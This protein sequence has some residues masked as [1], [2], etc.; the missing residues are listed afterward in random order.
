MPDGNLG[1]GKSGN[2]KSRNLGIEDIAP[3]GLRSD[4]MTFERLAHNR[5]ITSGSWAD[6]EDVHTNFLKSI[7]PFMSKHM[8]VAVSTNFECGTCSRI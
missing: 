8:S 3:L 6:I 5:S 2:W 7:F 1:I 4:D